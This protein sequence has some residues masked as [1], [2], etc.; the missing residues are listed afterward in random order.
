MIQ[1]LLE[2]LTENLLPEFLCEYIENVKENNQ[3]PIILK[4][5]DYIENKE[6]IILSIQGIEVLNMEDLVFEH[7][8][9]INDL[10]IDFETSLDL[11]MFNEEY[12]IMTTTSLKGSIII[13][14]YKR[15]FFIDKTD[16]LMEKSI[17]EN[18]KL[19]YL[20]VECSDKICV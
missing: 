7:K 13:T 16:L 1:E 6:E 15:H 11:S 19:Q 3:V 20:N 12:F 2:E 17:L 5:I 4:D 10:F 9:I 18:L 14:N 8:I